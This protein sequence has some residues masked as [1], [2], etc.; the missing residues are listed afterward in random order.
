MYCYAKVEI[1]HYF[2][3]QSYVLLFDFTRRRK[4]TNCGLFSYLI[5]RL[6]PLRHRPHPTL[7]LP[8][9]P[10]PLVWALPQRKAAD[11]CRKLIL[12]VAKKQTLKQ[13]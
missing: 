2:G 12:N 13:N 10:D 11:S 6:S 1:K 3:R 4:H 7:T 9:T 5:P 8:S